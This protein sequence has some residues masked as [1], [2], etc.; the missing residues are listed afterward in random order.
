MATVRSRNQGRAVIFGHLLVA[1][2]EIVIKDSPASLQRPKPAVPLPALQQ[3]PLWL[4][5][6][7]FY[8]VSVQELITCLMA[9]TGSAQEG[10][11]GKAKGFIL[12]SFLSIPGML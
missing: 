5:R 9:S 8:W 11:G 6:L 4:Y 2:P 3:S 7:G 1:I 10:G 12:L